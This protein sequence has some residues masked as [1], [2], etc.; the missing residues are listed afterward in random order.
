MASAFRDR[1][2][3]P[4][5]DPSILLFDRAV[6][7]WSLDL[8]PGA[9]VL[10]L[11]CCENNFTYWLNRAEPS[12]Q[13]T[14]VD[15]NDPREFHGTFIKGPAEAQAFAPKSFEAVILLGS[16]EH[17]GLGF[18]G[19]PLNIKADTITLE[20]ISEWL[21]P[22]GWCY[23]DVPWT[24]DRGY[25]TENRHFRVYDDDTLPM[26]DGMFPKRRMYAHGETNA[27]QWTRPTF[28]TTP[29]WYVQR[30]LEKTP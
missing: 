5:G 2:S 14:G 17:F 23:Y 19:D 13:I 28:P 3:Y 27:Q 25:I 20:K 21:V 8:P 22:G 16:L 4:E 9:R 7:A 30:L 24:P 6:R 26:A 18:Y 1:W 11:G 10:E 29:F 12:L 15:V